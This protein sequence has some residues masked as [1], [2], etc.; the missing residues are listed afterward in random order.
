MIVRSQPKRLLWLLLLSAAPVF[1]A[2][3]APDP[4]VRL[5]QARQR[6]DD[7]ARALAELHR[8]LGGRNAT[9]VPERRGLL[10][11]VLG[12]PEGDGVRVLGVTPGSGAEAAGMMAGDV[13]VAV[14][15]TP[16]AG[17]IRDFTHALE[18]AAAGD[19][20][21]VEYLRGRERATADVTMSEAQPFQ[22]PLPPPGGGGAVE[23][24]VAVASADASFIQFAPVGL[25]LH[26]FDANLGRYF[27]VASGVLVLQSA[28][29]SGLEGGDVLLTIADAPDPQ[30]PEP[31]RNAADAFGRLMRAGTG[32]SV[33]VLR[34]GGERTVEFAPGAL[35]SPADH[36]MPLH[37][38]GRIEDGFEVQ[39]LRSE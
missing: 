19:I 28:E 3:P 6:L 18:T 8:E 17:S 35:P 9:F 27:G 23:V 14:A 20:V 2:A 4:E 31:V 5:Q 30:A 12:P 36:L 13:V 7:A 33:T 22:L 34:D 24:G 26:D 11:I 32:V 10:G 25:Q 16:V 38:G 37:G 39:V 15:G 29:G 1:A 21:T